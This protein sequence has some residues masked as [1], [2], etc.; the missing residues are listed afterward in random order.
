MRG[1]AGSGRRGAGGVRVFAGLAQ[2]PTPSDAR[3]MRVAHQQLATPAL[4]VTPLTP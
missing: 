4:P 1:S 3:Q 2:I